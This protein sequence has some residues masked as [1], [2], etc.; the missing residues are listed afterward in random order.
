MTS[1][2]LDKMLKSLK[3]RQENARRIDRGLGR[4][5]EKL[6]RFIWP[7]RESRL[8]VLVFAVAVCDFLSTWL[9]LNFKSNT[10]ESGSLASWALNHG[11]YFSLFSIDIAV[12]GG[13]CAIALAL[14]TYYTRIG[15]P[16]YG[17]AAF[18]LVLLPYAFIAAL[19]VL[20]NMVF[21]LRAG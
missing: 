10:F 18:V 12:A 3:A 17:R 8:L 20:N 6:S 21:F 5:A 2:R 4:Y 9:G 15:S 11:G 7:W 1:E 16:D 19:A 13:L 14:R